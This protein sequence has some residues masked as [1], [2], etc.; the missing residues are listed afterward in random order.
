MTSILGCTHEKKK[1]KNEVWL[2]D[3]ERMELFRSISA[4]SEQ[5]IPIKN[6]PAMDAFICIGKDELKYWIENNMLKGSK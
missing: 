1:T 6:N 2:I 3:S 4:D 5:A